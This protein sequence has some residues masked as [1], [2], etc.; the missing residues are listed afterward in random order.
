MP[1]GIVREI[2]R[3]RMSK[4]PRIHRQAEPVE[5]KKRSFALPSAYTILF[6]LIILVAAATWFIPSGTYDYNEDGEPIPGTYH[7]IDHEPQKILLDSLKAPINGLYGIQDETGNISYWN[8]R[9]AVRRDRR[10]ALHHRHRRLSRR[11]D[12]D[13]RDQRRHRAVSSP[14]MQ[15]P[16]EVDDPGADGDLRPRRHVLRHGRR[17]ARL[18]SPDRRR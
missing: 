9:R 15:G 3:C 11:H 18:L 8:Y 10:R 12:E 1:I 5:P 17:D 14:R 2:R 16:R 13:R 7:E 6:I 4:S